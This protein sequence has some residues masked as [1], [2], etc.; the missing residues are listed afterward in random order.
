LEEKIVFYKQEWC[1]WIA[2][3]I[4][5]PIGIFLMW[6]YNSK[7]KENTKIMLSVAFAI[8]FVFTWAPSCTGINNSSSNQKA[9]QISS[10]NKQSAQSVEN[11]INAIGDPK[12]VSLDK[13]QSVK[14]AKNAYDALTSDQKGLISYNALKALIISDDNIATLEA[15]AAS[16]KTVADK[17]ATDQAAAAS[18][19]QSANTPTNSTVAT[20]TTSEAT[21]TTVYITDS[22]KKY[23][24]DGC[25]SL[26]KSKAP[27]ELE[28]A[29]AQGY[30]PCSKCNPPQ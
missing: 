20:Q 25:S 3:I 4:F 13:K 2:L 30:T 27:I 21:G 10:E 22:G 6:K 7:L 24:A 5:A 16:D 18:V 15:K 28:K 11:K 19:A 1:M 17:L 9:E 26:A 29:K 14:D 23:H 12:S 8:L